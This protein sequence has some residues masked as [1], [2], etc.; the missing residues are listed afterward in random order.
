MRRSAAQRRRAQRRAAYARI[1]S[2]GVATGGGLDARGGQAN[3]AGEGG[4][5]GKV[6]NPPQE[7]ARGGQRATGDAAVEARDP[8]AQ[9]ATR[10]H[11]RATSGT[12]RRGR[13]CS[14]SK[15]AGEDRRTGRPPHR[16]RARNQADSRR[17][18][19]WSRRTRSFGSSLFTASRV[20]CHPRARLRQYVSNHYHRSHD[21]DSAAGW[22]CMWQAHS[23]H[24]PN[25]ARFHPRL[26]T[27]RAA[28][29][30]CRH[31]SAHYQPRSPTRSPHPDPALRLAVQG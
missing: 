14:G 17:W 20:A 15:G 3:R 1:I 29:R 21:A 5:W 6:S 23:S 13:E 8:Q 28:A 16:R 19:R 10:A 2:N 24:R 25:H 22:A 12:R 7:L 26:G 9:G 27:H 11:A 18:R 30:H 4:R 31:R